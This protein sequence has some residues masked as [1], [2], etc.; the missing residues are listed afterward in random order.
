MRQ[1]TYITQQLSKK[2]HISEYDIRRLTYVEMCMANC[3]SVESNE[4]P[5]MEELLFTE[6]MMDEML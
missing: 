5:D 6:K 2:L 1:Y 4:T 3:W